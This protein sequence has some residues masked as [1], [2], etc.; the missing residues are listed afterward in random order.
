MEKQGPLQVA[1]NRLRTRDMRPF[2]E[3]VRDVAEQALEREVEMLTRAI[4][5]LSKT[6]AK[7]AKNLFKLDENRKQLA[8]NVA[9]KKS[10]LDVDEECLSLIQEAA[11]AAHPAFTPSGSS[12]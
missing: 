5:E 11:Q 3:K 8:A 1:E 2:R 4:E 9:D 12:Q 7:V 6:L 10:A